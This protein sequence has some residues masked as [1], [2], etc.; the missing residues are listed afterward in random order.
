MAGDECLCVITHNP[1][2]FLFQMGKYDPAL[3]H[4]VEKPVFIID[5]LEVSAVCFPMKSFT[6]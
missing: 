1:Y 6:F 5:W 4:L 2:L 3:Q